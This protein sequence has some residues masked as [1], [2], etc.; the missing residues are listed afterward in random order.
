MRSTPMAF[1]LTAPRTSIGFTSALRRL[2][3]RR[4]I[5]ETPKP[6]AQNWRY[7]RPHVLTSCCIGSHS[8]GRN[9]KY[10]QPTCAYPTFSCVLYGRSL[11]SESCPSPDRQASNKYSLHGG[12]DR[13]RLSRSRPKTP[14]QSR[15]GHS[16]N[17][18]RQGGCRYRGRIGLVHG[19]S[20]AAGRSFGHGLRH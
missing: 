9:E 12:P 14:H 18:A 11:R 1:Q 4:A 16:G 5:T 8:K 20:G 19:T 10:P 15:D 6:A 17:C 7:N 3:H 13:I 2:G